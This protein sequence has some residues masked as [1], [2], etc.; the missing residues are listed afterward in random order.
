MSTIGKIFNHILASRLERYMLDNAIVDPELQKGF[1]SG[2]AGVFEHILALNTIIDNARMNG[3]PISMTFIDLRNALVQS[4]TSSFWTCY[5]DHISV[6]AQM[7]TYVADMYSK[8]TA[9]ISTSKW[10]TPPF[11][12][13]RGIIQGDTLSRLLF[14]LCYHPVIAYAEK[15]PTT[16]FQMTTT[17]L[18]QWVYLLL[19]ST[20][21][22]SGR[23]SLPR[24]MMD[25]T[26]VK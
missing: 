13:T 10:C 17:C 24:N 19:T 18:I 26:T 21:M 15:L 23:R 2:I 11:Q 8:L 7:R 9:S 25:G 4:P 16:G 20:F 3:H 1:L 6:P 14:L 12:I 5:I 22:W